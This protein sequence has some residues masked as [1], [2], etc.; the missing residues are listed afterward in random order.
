MRLPYC[1]S[2][3]SR[4]R[5]QN[6]LLFQ[7]S[8]FPTLC[9]IFSISL[10]SYRESLLM[11]TFGK[12]EQTIIYLM[13]YFFLNKKVIILIYS[14]SSVICTWMRSIVN[15]VVSIVHN[16]DSLGKLSNSLIDVKWSFYIILY[17]FIWNS[18]ICK[19]AKCCWRPPFQRETVMGFMMLSAFIIVGAV[20]WCLKN[21]CKV[22][23][24][25]PE[26]NICECDPCQAGEFVCFAL[27]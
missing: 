1:R 22:N 11:F 21:G 25:G 24:R 19:I 7:G 18:L 17:S 9:H 2:A 13:W 16:Y 3:D 6:A 14:F 10:G 4:M 5:M 8:I 15:K 12:H 27:C 20:L 26:E 23:R